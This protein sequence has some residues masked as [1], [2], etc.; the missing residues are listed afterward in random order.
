MEPSNELAVFGGLLGGGNLPSSLPVGVARRRRLL[1]RELHA[2]LERLVR[3]EAQLV[4]ALLHLR[5]VVLGL[6]IQGILERY[7]ARVGLSREAS[8]FRQRRR[9]LTGTRHGGVAGASDLVEARL[10]LVAER[11]RR[12]PQFLDDLQR[13]VVV[14]VGAAS[15]GR[16]RG[17]RQ[18]GAQDFVGRARRVR[19]RGGVDDN[20]RVLEQRCDVEPREDVRDVYRG[21]LPRPWFDEEAVEVQ[22]GPVDLGRGEDR[23]H[24]ALR[25]FYFGRRCLAAQ[26]VHGRRYGRFRI[27]QGPRDRAFLG[28]G[29][30]YEQEPLGALGVVVESF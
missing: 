29:A 25:K 9:Q 26:A 27:P 6:L 10:V 22:D 4:L 7:D 11:R 16:S 2:A 17:R 13:G 8:L 19:E 23:D 20:G 5:G 12:E 28:S 21:R 24:P 3:V 15:R 14:E 18:R 1:G 30:T